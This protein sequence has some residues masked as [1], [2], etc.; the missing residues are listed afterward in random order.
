MNDP[1][2]YGDIFETV[3][4]LELDRPN[5]EAKRGEA[6]YAIP[7]IVNDNER[8]VC[9]ALGVGETHSSRGEF[10]RLIQHESS[11]TSAMIG[12]KSLWEDV[13]IFGYT[14]EEIESKIHN[15]L[16]RNFPG[17]VI[18]SSGIDIKTISGQKKGHL[19][20]RRKKELFYIPRD[21]EALDCADD[22]SLEDHADALVDFASDLLEEFLDDPLLAKRDRLYETAPNF[23]Q[24]LA[25][26][27]AVDSIENAGGLSE[28]HLM[29][30]DVHP[31][32]GKDIVKATL[33]KVL[34]EKY[35]CENMIQMTAVL[36]ANNTF[37]G[38]IGDW[39]EFADIQA[40]DYREDGMK[41]LRHRLRAFMVSMHED[42]EVYG[43][44]Y[45]DLIDIHP[46]NRFFIVEEND[47]AANTSKKNKIK[48]KLSGH[49]GLT[50]AMSGTNS[51]I[52]IILDDSSRKRTYIS[53]P[54][55]KTFLG[56]AGE[57]PELTEDYIQNLDPK[58]NRHEKRFLET[59]PGVETASETLQY[60]PDLSIRHIRHELS[61][62]AKSEVAAA[63]GHKW[64]DVFS[65]SENVVKTGKPFFDRM[66]APIE[67]SDEQAF[68]N[69]GI[70]KTNPQPYNVG[71]RLDQIEGYEK[72]EHPVFVAFLP[73]NTKNSVVED[74]VDI[75][76]GESDLDVLEDEGGVLENTSLGEG[77]AV[78][79]TGNY[80][81]DE[82]AKNWLEGQV[83]E[84]K[85]QGKDF[86]VAFAAQLGAR[87]FTYPGIIVLNLDSTDTRSLKVQRLLRSFSPGDG[88]EMAV[89]LDYA[90][91]E[92]PMPG[93][94][95]IENAARKCSEDEDTH[96]TL[97]EFVKCPALDLA[98]IRENE[99]KQVKT[100]KYENLN[101]ESVAAIG[102]AASNSLRSV[103]REVGVSFPKTEIVDRLKGAKTRDGST[104]GADDLVPSEG[105]DP[106][107]DDDND[108][109]DESGTDELEEKFE[110]EL[111]NL[112]EIKENIIMG[113]YDIYTA[114][115]ITG[116]TG[117]PNLVPSLRRL[118]EAEESG[119]PV[120]E[121]FVNFFGIKPSDLYAVIQ[122]SLSSDE[123]EAFI[124]RRQL[125]TIDFAIS[126]THET[127]KR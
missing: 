26:V 31:R 1:I 116:Y 3:R 36:P 52:E 29:V 102:A 80:T 123:S 13:G 78:T 112:E 70:Q 88:V 56:K 93:S 71:I 126:S 37:E 4:N 55:H 33:G 60:F 5:R 28:D 27:Q 53:Y 59:H 107:P 122:H 30:L 96:E 35:G 11:K 87:S 72:P 42:A 106:S 76:N 34:N 100:F 120:V 32:G 95:L 38:E 51:E 67:K 119:E 89:V 68:G 40:C 46:S 84:S 19:D 104:H 64:S 113:S 82:N 9:V 17:S 94:C 50:V 110:D 79:M 98:S 49:T 121:E 24:K 23:Y 101:H 115:L 108:E 21:S 41:K 2:E 127:K 90:L 7:R 69:G 117:E 125:D 25:V 61:D 54:L 114:A 22:C 57:I 39:V 6:V 66:F 48:E 109:S 44:R 86:T 75:M 99:H 43:D 20:S 12:R 14:A 74:V 118:V 103:S 91:Q 85:R 18:E 124:T 16:E 10:K 73:H 47:Q 65:D 58:E 62:Q 77:R 81:S 8:G 63:G 92:P 111:S 45:D 15:Y 105:D 97:K 83:E